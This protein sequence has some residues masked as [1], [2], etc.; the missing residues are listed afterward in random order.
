MKSA[1]NGANQPS[2]NNVLEQLLKVIN[3]N[4]DF[5][6]KVSVNMELMQ[7]NPAKMAMYSIVIGIPQV[8]LMLLANIETATKL[9]YGREFFSTMHNIRKKYTCNHVHDATLLQIIL[10]ELAGTGSVRVLNDTPAM[11]I[12]TA[13]LVAKLVSYLHDG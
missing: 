7:L 1:I 4:F 12:G 13:H 2:P 3:H 8:M 5:C 10:K 11:G 9:D 6:K